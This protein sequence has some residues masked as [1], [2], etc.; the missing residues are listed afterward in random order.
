MALASGCS[1]QAPTLPSV[2]SQEAS[3]GIQLSFEIIGADAN[4]D[5]LEWSV[6]S[7]TLEDIATRG[8]PAT[9]TPFDSQSAYFRW[10]PLTSDVGSHT[11]IVTADDG[12]QQ[13]E[14]PVAVTVSSGAAVPVF[15]EPLGSGTTLD[16]RET[17]CMSVDVV[18]ED[19][20]GADVSLTLQEPIEEGYDFDQDQPMAGTFSFCPTD[21]Q[22]EAAER[23][24]VTF[25][26]EDRDGHI[27]T[28]KYLIVLR[29]DLL[30]GCPGDG[31]QISHT[32]D[33][34]A[35]TVLD[36]SI[37]AS[38]SDD[39]AV[40]GA[41]VLYFSTVEPT[42]P[43]SLDVASFS[44]VEMT[45]SSGTAQSGTY[46]G[47]IPNPVLSEPVG[48]QRSLYYFIEASD[49]DDAAGPCDHRS[50]A[51]IDD[52]YELVVERPASGAGL[53]TCETCSADVQCDSGR[54]IA[55]GG[56]EVQCLDSCSGPGDSCATGTCSDVAWASVDS[57]I[58]NVCLPD[59]DSCQDACAPDAYEDNDT[60]DDPGVT[61]LADGSYDDLTICVGPTGAMD[62]DYFGLLL[63]DATPM[64]AVVSF[65][66]ADG[67]LDLQ[68][69]DEDG[70]GLESS[71][72]VGDVESVNRCL[73]PGLYFL[74]VYSPFAGIN[75]S[76]DLDLSLPS[77]GCCAADG[78][79]PDDGMFDAVPVSAG[80]YFGDRSICPN[81]EDWYEIDLE[82]GDTVEVTLLFDQ[83]TSD[84]DLD[85]HFYDSSGSD[86]T[87]CPPCD[88]DN[89]Q[90]GSADEYFEYSVASTD[91]FY[92][93]VQGFEGAAAEYL[94]DF[95]VR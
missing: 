70:G 58:G 65:A 91:T 79:E 22:I 72:G 60:I 35:S 17:D 75:T 67:D 4:N 61:D 36:L 84:Q 24:P 12:R 20:D 74:R 11:L 42:D 55:T 85:I 53:G 62:D 33:A 88:I 29:R 34:N 38:I 13:T 48:S 82:A 37:E 43:T 15:R 56:G 77:G 66:H 40:H 39:I 46:T 1:N 49:N 2:P 9:L 54:C 93:V 86:L 14:L 64:E 51:P 69:L 76:Y 27:A 94:I 41:P 6:S 18:V 30:T 23:Y 28:K 52:V 47:S 5:E 71:L 45:L 83:A 3:V 73:A 8:A 25:V 81:D 63:G 95:D 19:A 31:P 90:S 68:L 89:G 57:A 87:P 7:S 26:A 80:D 50:T 16:L 32:S 59:E 44:Q 10:T 21:K 78:E 92:V